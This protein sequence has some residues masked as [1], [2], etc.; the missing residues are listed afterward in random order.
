MLFSVALD[1]RYGDQ[2]VHSVAVHPGA[3]RTELGRHMTGDDFKDLLKGRPQA[4]PMKFKEIPQGAA[5]TVWATTTPEFENRGG[6]YCEDCG[7]APV[8]DEPGVSQGVMGWAL[9]PEAADRLWALSEEW[10]GEKF[11][12]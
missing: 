5:T 2:G 6:V 1:R 10:S 8:I 7:I 4:E 11:P 3:I 12:S 9:D